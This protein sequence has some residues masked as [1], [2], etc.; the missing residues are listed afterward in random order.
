M[1]TKT[2][3]FTPNYTSTLLN[4][5]FWLRSP[6]R[7]WINLPN[8]GP[9]RVHSQVYTTYIHMQAM[10]LLLTYRCTYYPKPSSTFDQRIRAKFVLTKAAAA[11]FV[12]SPLGL[13]SRNWKKLAKS[14][15]PIFAAEICHGFR[16][17]EYSLWRQKN[18]RWIFR[19]QGCQIFRGTMYQ[20]VENIPNDH[21]I[22]QSAT[23]Y[24]CIQSG[25]KMD[26]MA[27]CK[28]YQHLPLQYP[29]KFTQIGIFGLKIYHLATLSRRETQTSKKRF[30]SYVGILSPLYV[31]YDVVKQL[32]PMLGF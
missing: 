21:K 22:Y 18:F 16:V 9:G 7:Q 26:Q 1:P 14:C 31:F 5:L 30:G 3:L 8:D 20:N 11:I 13:I 19:G 32:G 17:S 23:K 12:L 4:V 25:L 6:R 10:Y 2:H 15:C 29:R 27:I 28:I 24:V